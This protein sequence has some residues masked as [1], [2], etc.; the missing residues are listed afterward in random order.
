MP[1]RRFV[2]YPPRIS[3]TEVQRLK[4]RF[5]ER[6]EH[7]FVAKRDGAY[8][9]RAGDFI[10]GW[11]YSKA[12][13]WKQA[14]EQL[15][16]RWFNHHSLILNAVRKMD[17]FELLDEA[18]IPIPKWTK[19]RQRAKMWLDAGAIV[20]A[21]TT[22]DSC[23]GEGI[24]VVKPGESLPEALFYTVFIPSA[25]E[26]RV[27]VVNGTVVDVLEK[28]PIPRTEQ[29]EYIKGSEDMGWQFCRQG[30]YLSAQAKSVAIA[31]VVALGLDFGGVDIL[32]S[33]T[34][35]TVLEVNT[36][37]DIFGSGVDRFIDAFTHEA[38][39]AA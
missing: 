15:N 2:I 1:D 7:C 6:G 31:A 35:T 24:T 14:A 34:A 13:I 3:C 37:P 4:D 30:V 11:G 12:P 8:T 17:S 20:F 27:Y 10:L 26:F 29:H 33:G 38:Q 5:K 36:A 28:R 18:G 39:K 19:L 23:R 9:P 22:Q 32:T 16:L 25:S 21:R